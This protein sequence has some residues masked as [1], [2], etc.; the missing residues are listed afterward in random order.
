MI[1]NRISKLCSDS[2]IFNESR[3]MYIQAL[4]SAGYK[5]IEN[6]F[7]Y[8]TETTPKNKSRKR[9]II[10]YN[11]PFNKNVT[12]KIGGGLLQLVKKHFPI[13]HN[14]HKIFNK[15]TIKVSY[16]CTRNMADILKSS[17]IKKTQQKKNE[18]Q[19]CKC[20]TCPL[21]GNCKMECIVYKAKITSEIKT[22]TKES[23]SMTEGS[24]MQ[25]LYGHYSDQNL[26]HAR[27]KTDLS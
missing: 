27:Y 11:P 15:N 25:H 9:N 12:S 10:W 17:N 3:N 16:C 8:K 2:T 22:K 24:F 4:T 18:T 19:E 7:K 21:D 6:K 13:D 23:F 26:K 20:D 1:S 14:L 5:D